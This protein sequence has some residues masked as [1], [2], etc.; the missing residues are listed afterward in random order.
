MEPADNAHPGASPAPPRPVAAD[1][2]PHTARLLLTDTEREPPSRLSTAWSWLVRGVVGVSGVASAGCGIAAVNWHSIWTA[3][4]D[5]DMESGQGTASLM[6]VQ[7]QTSFQQWMQLALIW[8]LICVAGSVTWWLIAVK[9][10]A[11]TRRLARAVEEFFDPDTARELLTDTER[12][13]RIARA[14]RR[15]VAIPL[16]VLGLLTI[17]YA[18]L[19]W[20]EQRLTDVGDDRPALTT[21]AGTYYWMTFGAVGLLI[22]GLWF[23]WRSRRTGAGSDAGSWIAVGVGLLLLVNAAGLPLPFAALL[24][25]PPFVTPTV[26]V[27]PLLLIS[28]RRRSWHLGGWVIAF[29]VI[30]TAASLLFFTNRLD[31]LVHLL[32]LREVVPFSAIVQADLLVLLL[33]GPVLI[34]AARRARHAEVRDGS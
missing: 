10:A 29:A 28:M 14:D 2:E 19:L 9:Q 23:G 22:I 8:L 31:D 11:G 18:V 27:L 7:A 26:I 1:L 34:V 16:L 21:L 24:F 13:R 15:G 3:F 4:A 33:L 30:T 32:G 12:V 5:A 20:L 17:G 25:I 6:T